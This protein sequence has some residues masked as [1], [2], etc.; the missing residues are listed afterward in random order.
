MI[1]LNRK[2]INR[3][4]LHLVALLMPAGIFYLPEVPPFSVWTAPV[5]LAGLFSLSAAADKLKQTNPAFS[6]R[7]VACFGA[8]LR[9]HEKTETT[10]A[11]TIIGGALICA[12][13]FVESPHISFVVLFLFILGDA[14]AALVGQH[15]GRIRLLGKSLEGSLA[16]FGV[17]MTL[18]ALIFPHV[19]GL[20]ARWQGP[21]PFSLM[22]VGS[23]AVTILELVPVRISR[24]RPLD[25]NL[26]VPVAAGTIIGLFQSV[27]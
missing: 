24:K 3:K 19:P 5:I 15:A 12:V 10:G 8:L 22:V 20:T 18:F 2:E 1:M 7:Y 23:L 13:V 6:R 17:C 26:Y 9:P 27:M 14:A 4:L 25:D 11:T 16:C 21:I